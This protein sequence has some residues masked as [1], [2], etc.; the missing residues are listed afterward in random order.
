MQFNEYQKLAKTTRKET[1][2]EQYVVY[3]MVGEVGEFCSKLAKIIRDGLPEDAEDEFEI[4]LKK[5]VGDI[6]WH[7]SAICDDIGWDLDDVAQMNLDKLKARQEKGTI[8]GSGD[9]R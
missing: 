2:T 9:D 6:L 7:L 4:G 5:E 8:S 3:N 1:A